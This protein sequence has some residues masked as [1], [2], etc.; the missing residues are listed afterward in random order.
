[1]ERI[2][3]FIVWIAL[4][5]GFFLSV[6]YF[7]SPK[8]K[9]LS[10]KILS[11]FLFSLLIEGL[12]V[13]L[14]FNEIFGYKLSNYFTTPEVKLFFPVL[15]FHYILKKLGRVAVYKRHLIVGY[16]LAFIILA[17]TPFNI[18]LYLSRGKYIYDWFTPYQ[19]EVLF[20][21]QQV[22]A[23]TLSVASLV[24]SL[25][26]LRRHKRIANEVHSD[27]S[28]TQ[29]N[30]LFRFI[31]ILGFISL[32]WGMELLRIALGAIGGD[33]IVLITWGVV[34]LFIYYVS[35]QAF[36]RP[37]L[38]EESDPESD[39]VLEAN[40]VSNSLATNNKESMHSETIELLENAMSNQKLYLNTDLTI[41]DLARSLTIS[42]RK[43]SQSINTLNA[44]NFSE[45]VNNFRVQEA[46]QYLENNSENN[47][48][49]EGI[50]QES[51]FKSRS[52]M[53]SAFKKITGK[54]PG[55]FRS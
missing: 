3:S 36:V 44:Q 18:T 7:L 32:L 9:S 14:P 23:F 26:E 35:Y 20:M 53:Y 28:L 11:L 6:L 24:V 48:S 16:T 38:F 31:L 39:V 13:F 49:I 50:G 29:V 22:L 51:G 54:S 25:I 40:E 4:A 12:N 10:N 8:H 55:D 17:L 37:D 45:W 47:L 43:I 19:Y 27:I 52:A 1:M 42:A 2:I 34:C 5:Q 15:A 21:S 46:I 30:W 33:E 41:H